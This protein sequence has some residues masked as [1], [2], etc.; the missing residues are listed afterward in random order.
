MQDIY[1][2]PYISD[3]EITLLF[4]LEIGTCG[5]EIILQSLNP[6]VLVTAHYYK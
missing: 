5:L 4:Y 3:L 1:L 6:I 2:E